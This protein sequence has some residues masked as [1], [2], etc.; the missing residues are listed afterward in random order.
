MKGLRW[1]LSLL[2][3]RLQHASEFSAWFSE[4]FFPP[5]ATPMIPW[6]Q[7]SNLVSLQS[8]CWIFNLLGHEGT[9]SVFSFKG[10]DKKAWR[11]ELDP[12]RG[13]P[14]G[15]SEALAWGEAVGP[16]GWGCTNSTAGHARLTFRFAFLS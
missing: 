5:L 2:V 13:T 1:H 16:T 3:I 12:C 9:P 6:G 8:Q 14:G 11:T 10:T 15:V 4:F 7:R